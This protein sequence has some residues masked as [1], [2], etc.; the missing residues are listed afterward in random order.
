MTRASEKSL[1]RIGVIGSR[2]RCHQNRNSVLRVQ[3]ILGSENAYTSVLCESG[4]PAKGLAGVCHGLKCTGS[5]KAVG[6]YGRSTGT[7]GRVA[8]GDHHNRSKDGRAEARGLAGVRGRAPETQVSADLCGHSV[9]RWLGTISI[10]TK[11]MMTPRS[12]VSVD[13]DEVDG[14]GDKVGDNKAGGVG[15]GVN[16]SVQCAD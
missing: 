3:S 10:D 2:T 1:Y 6:S 7:K 15:G 16:T 13:D 11:V 9:Q 14:V 12:G 8:E 5:M 4:T